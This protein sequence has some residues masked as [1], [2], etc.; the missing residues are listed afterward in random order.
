MRRL[1]S[2]FFLLASLAFSAERLQLKVV[3]PA[4]TPVHEARVTLLEPGSDKVLDLVYTDPRGIASL[5]VMSDR[6]VSIEVLAPGFASERLS[7]NQSPE[8]AEVRLHVAVPTQAVTVTAADTELSLEHTA[9][10][11]AVITADEIISRNPI[12]AANAIQFVPGVVIATTGRRGSLSSALVRGGESR[13]NKVIIDGVTVNDPGGTFDFGVVPMQSVE[14]IELLRGPGSTLYGSDAMTSVVQL[15]S[16]T[17]SSRVPEFTFG[18]DGGTFGTAHGYAGLAGAW[19][20]FDYNVFAD[21]FATEGQGVNDAHQNA[22]QG[23]N[24]GFQLTDKWS[25][26]LRARHANSRSDVQNAWVFNDVALLSPDTDQYARQNN[27]LASGELTWLPSA[28]WKH[29]LRGGEYNHHRRNVDQESDRGCDVAN[30][31]FTDCFFDV[32]ARINRATFDYQGEFSPRAYART[33]YGYQYEN[34]NGNLLSDFLTLDFNT[35]TPYIE[36]TQTRGL[37]RN[38]ALYVQQLLVWDRISFLAGVRYTHNESFGDRGVPQAS[39]SWLALGDHG[40]L[41]GTR[42]RVGYGEGIKEPRFEESFGVTGTFPTFPNP[43]LKSEQNRAL[44]AG[45]VQGLGPWATFSATYFNNLFRNQIFF[46]CDPMTFQCRYEN[47]GKSLAHGAEVSLNLRPSSA[48]S[49]DL[50]YVYTS[51][52]ILQ[53]PQAVGVFRAGEPLLRRPKNSGSVTA[54]YFRNRWGMNASALYIGDRAD[55]DFFVLTTPITVADA[56]SRVDL[57]GWFR[58]NRYAVA[59]VNLENL[60]NRRYEEVLGYPALKANFRAGMRFRVGGE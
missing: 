5:K 51:T 42:L 23:A 46:F 57:G 12:N 14:R 44:E 20:K 28:R 35:F 30:F 1:L 22:S 10:S 16:T 58:V 26:R 41:R 45:L 8:T 21:Q 25:F 31:D 4:G 59:Y 38:H 24:L 9:A 17:G 32:N 40:F 54:N 3:D 29:T 60:F 2:S 52:Q 18:A 56:Y 34:E 55:S 19:S 49:L 13:Y 6:K 36:H 11:T 37:R 27:F 50:N 47:L 15:F 7:L 53:S 39:L 48:F 43:D 33:V